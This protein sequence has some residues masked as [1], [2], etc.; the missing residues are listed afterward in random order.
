MKISKCKQ[1]NHGL[2][3]VEA[4]VVISV[5]AFGTLLLLPAFVRKGQK[6]TRISCA[7]KLQQIGL[8]FRIWEGDHGDHFPMS[9]Y[10]NK[11]GEP[12]F[13]NAANGYRY[14]QVMSNELN[15]P[16]IL[17]CPADTTRTPATNWD[18]G[19]N[20][21]HISYFIALEADETFPQMFLAGDSNLT[22]GTKLKDG[23]MEIT[24][25]PSVGFTKERHNGAGNIAMADGS[26]QQ[27]STAAL[28]AA[29]QHTSKTT[30]LVTNR[31]LFPDGQ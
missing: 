9:A 2:T 23:I 30:G 20:G 5:I 31:L 7:Y 17:I 1:G 28:Q 24:S 21:R 27:F 11:L 3:L 13:A 15:N 4:L 12:L 6:S 16:K 25:N 8:A 10:T 29:L 18:P 19:F 14:F 22:N 26:V